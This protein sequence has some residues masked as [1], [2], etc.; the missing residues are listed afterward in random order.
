MTG[1]AAKRVSEYPSPPETV[2]K[3]K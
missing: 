2:G 3:K 1:E